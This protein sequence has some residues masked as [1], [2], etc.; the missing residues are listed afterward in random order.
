MDNLPLVSVLVITYN[1][2]STVVDTLN[3][4]YSQTYR[5]IELIITDDASKDNT[6]DVCKKWVSDHK[7]RFLGVRIVETAVNTGIAG[8]NNRGCRAANGDW[9]KGIAGDDTMLDDCIE[10]LVKFA[11][12]D[13]TFQIVCGKVELTG[14]KQDNYGNEIWN[15]NQKLPRIL[16][17]AKEQNWYLMRR[18]F[19]PAMGSMFRKSLW[20]KV[21]GFDEDIPLLD[22]WPFWLNIT[23]SG[24]MIHFCD[25]IVAR[26]V[27]SD[28]S[29]RSNYRFSYSVRLFQYKYIYKEMGKFHLL[30]KMN[31][32]NNKTIF[33]KIVHS[34]VARDIKNHIDLW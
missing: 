20:E 4:I 32:L 8:N 17:S 1:S 18:N 33:S 16:E 25:D 34:I 19:I 26:Y 11:E 5:N 23:N 28:G 14:V 3:S 15:Y 13:K 7:G 22:D 6:I 2:A 10:K 27:I 9:I 31:F 29:V 30:K 12:S 24:E 21:G